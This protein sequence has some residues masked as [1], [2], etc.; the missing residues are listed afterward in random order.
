[1]AYLV[2]LMPRAERDLT[3]IFWAKNVEHSDAARNWY[4]GLREAVFSLEEQPHRCPETLENSK[5]RHL[6]YGNKP[7]FYGI[8]YRILERE[9]IV[10]IVHIRH[11]ARKKFTAP[12][13]D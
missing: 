12:T 6:L 5:V 7:H 1:M 8:I 3:N 9:K 10:E 13:A 11:G 2:K 4:L